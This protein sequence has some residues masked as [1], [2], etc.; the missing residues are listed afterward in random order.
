MPSMRSALFRVALLAGSV[1][2]FGLT[3]QAAVLLYVFEAWVCLS[4]GTVARAGARRAAPAQ[5]GPKPLAFA[6]AAIA[7][8]A[9]F[10]LVAAYVVSGILYPGDSFGSV[11]AAAARDPGMLGS[12]ALVLVA[13]GLHG[14]GRVR[15]PAVDA[16]GCAPDARFVLAR[17]WVLVLPAMLLDELRFAPAFE[18]ALMLAAMVASILVFEGLPLRELRRLERQLG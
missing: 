4:L 7:L 9:P 2:A 8:F 17:A 6:F 15:R 5:E 16:A 1:L 14:L 13:E 11:L 12:A 3:P 10:C 18:A